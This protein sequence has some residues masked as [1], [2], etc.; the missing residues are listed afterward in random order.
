MKNILVLG[1]NGFLGS[2]FCKI[3]NKRNYKIFPV[4]R[5]S[6]N[7]KRFRKLN[8]KGKITI[9]KYKDISDTHRIIKFIKKYN[10]NILINFAAHGVLFRK[11][12]KDFKIFN[13]VNYLD[14]KNLIQNCLELKL[15]K[16]VHIG[17]ISEFGKQKGKIY[18]GLKE[19][20]FDKYSLSKLNF[21]NF[22]KFHHNKSKLPFIL[23]R[24]FPIYGPLENKKKLFPYIIHNIK[25]NLKVKLTSG[26]QIRNYTYVDDINLAIIKCIESKKILNKSLI[27]GNE[28]SETLK[29]IVYKI[30]NTL[31]KKKKLIIWNNIKRKDENIDYVPDLKKTKKLLKWKPTISLEVGVKKMEKYL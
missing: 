20:A 9:L 17:T 27:L 22:L 5:Y 7:L 29:N 13:K 10:I 1:A 16:Y 12:A 30:V 23:L 6:S 19:N 14:V 3:L 26:K 24:L 28:K 2:H 25:K 4:V 18:D 11:D 15:E 31:K 8:K 21:T